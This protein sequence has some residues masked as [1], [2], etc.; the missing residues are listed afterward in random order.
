V[1]KQ[2]SIA[3]AEKQVAAIKCAVENKVMV[4]TGG[5]GTGK[6]TIINA[7]LKIFSKLKVKIMLA[8]PTGR[9][10]KK[11]SEAENL[12]TELQN[13]LNPGE[14]GIMRGNKDFRIND[15][16]MQ[17]KNDRTEKR[18]TYL[19]CRLLDNRTRTLKSISH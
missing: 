7:V 11:M 4:I 15:K 16:V 6:T 3:L 2:L 14:G 10:A 8:A 17:I 19:K 12:N 5:P 9:A 18:Y 13:A 1:Q